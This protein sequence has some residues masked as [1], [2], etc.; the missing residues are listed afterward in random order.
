[1]LMA[2]NPNIKVE[3][4]AATP[5]YNAGMQTLL[6]GAVTGDMPDITFPGINW[7]RVVVDR[8]LAQPID[9]LVAAEDEWEARGYSQALM[10]VATFEGKLYGLPLAISTPVVFY[11]ADLVR[12]AGGDPASLPTDWDGLFDLA[13]RIDALGDDI[14]GMHL[15]HYGGTWFWQ[16]LITSQGGRIMTPDETS[17][18]FDNE[19]GLGALRLYDRAMKEGG[20][21]YMSFG[22]A[23]KAFNAGQLGFYINSTAQIARSLKD[24]GERFELATGPHPLPAGRE[25][26]RLVAGGNVGMILTDDEARRAAAF[27]YIKLAASAWGSTVTVTETGYMPVNKLAADDAEYLKAF[28]E[29]NPIYTTTLD[30]IDVITTWYAFPGENG[31]KAYKAI[32]DNVVTVLTGEATPEAALEQMTADVNALVETAD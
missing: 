2:D 11:N 13:G 18:A 23:K 24:I 16:S 22:D 26:G 8:G 6:R 31:L 21:Q 4:K 27:E 29:E 10:D 20:M 1:K 28:Y 12:Q 25:K 30:Q 19:V 15:S 5:D 14:M 17:V 7:Q 9:D 3:F 32:H